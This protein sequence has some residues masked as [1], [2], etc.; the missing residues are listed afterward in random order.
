MYPATP[1]LGFVGG[2]SG[3]GRRLLRLLQRKLQ[4][5]PLLQQAAGVLRQNAVNQMQ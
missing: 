3:G 1:H 2:S 5:A 4:V